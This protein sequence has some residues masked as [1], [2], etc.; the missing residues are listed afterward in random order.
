MFTVDE[1]LERQYPK[2]YH[3]SLLCPP[4][5]PIL[6]KLLREKDF[7]DFSLRYPHLQDID[8]VEQV[9]EYFHFSYTV[10]SHDLEN[11][12]AQ[13]RV[14]IVANHPIGTLDGLALYKLIREVRSDVRIV[15]NTLLSL[16]GP[17]RSCM[18]PVNTMGGKSRK[19]NIRELG[20]ALDH[21]EAII[22]FPAG[23]VSRLG[24]KGVKDCRWNK[25]F[26]TLAEKYQAP[27]LPIHIKGKNSPGFYTASLLC[28][29]L[30]TAM[31]IGEMFKQQRRRIQLTVGDIIPHAAYRDIPLAP[32]AKAKLFKK[33]VYR[34]GKGRKPVFRTESG[35]ARPER[36]SDLKKA[37]ATA[38]LL[39]TTPDK[40]KIFL[41]QGADSSPILRE[42]GRLREI[43]FRTVGEGSG[44]RRDMD[45]YDNTYQQLILWD[46]DDLEIVGAYRFADAQQTIAD[47]GVEGLY[48]SALFHLDPHT[49][50]F[51]EQGLE[52]GRSFVQ[53]RYWGKR[54][55]DYLWYGIGA[56]LAKNP[57][58][59]YLF[60]PVSISNA[61]PEVARELL[62]FFYDLYFGMNDANRSSKNPFHF[63]RP[64]EEL[65]SS[66]Q[67]DDYKKDFKQLKLLLANMGT[68]V[69]TLYKQYID[70]CKPGGARFLGFN[71]DPDFNNCVDGLVILDLT[72]LKK[73]KRKRYIESSVLTDEGHGKKKSSCA[74]K[75]QEVLTCYK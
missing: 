40:K 23:E 21:E 14:V 17:L 10:S 48:T 26:L 42:I 41:Y 34:I 3:N 54:S 52:L 67:G 73:R 61:I 11:I 49:H 24:P 4:V 65:R 44:L 43:T 5:K 1:V 51:L 45:R 74:G 66:F 16:I 50:N 37:L 8:F 2:I 27:V 32:A 55:L 36:R 30:S 18:I 70:L 59:R 62:I 31:L 12:P 38:E 15:A 53:K 71:V 19:S 35:I 46:E 58:Y 56:F 47:Q 29:P 9:L 63:S 57:E 13:G 20:R 22:I 39:G 75:Q 7:L 64:L 28:K 25:G 69:P 68:A 6:R 72:Q 33:H 60:G